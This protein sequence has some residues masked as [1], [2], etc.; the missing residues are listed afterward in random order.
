MANFSVSLSV[1]GGS[2]PAA[3]S[4]HVSLEF[5][6]MFMHFAVESAS[7]VEFS[8]DGINVHGKLHNTAYPSLLMQMRRR[9][10]WFRVAAGTDPA[11]TRASLW[12]L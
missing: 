1:T 8:F 9:K 2:F 7:Q 12:S 10:V 4:P 11:V 3:A 5:D 6:P